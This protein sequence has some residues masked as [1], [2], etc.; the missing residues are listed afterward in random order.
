MK[1]GDLVRDHS[2]KELAIILGLW[3]RVYDDCNV[4]WVKCLWANGDVEEVI[5]DDV[6]MISESR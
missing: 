2:T 3:E 5:Q 1:L 4:M 6:E